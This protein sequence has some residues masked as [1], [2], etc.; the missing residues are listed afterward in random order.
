M[1][2]YHNRPDATAEALDRDGWLRTGD[3]GNLD[4]KGFLTI[5]DRKKDLIKTSAGKYVAPR[6]LEGRLALLPTEFSVES[7]ELTP[8]LKPRRRVIEQK[9][10]DV[11][12][13]LYEGTIPEAMNQWAPGREHG[14]MRPS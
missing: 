13:S 8:S 11:L 10:A 7:G 6:A 2:R 9:Y 3:I 14:E 1:R 5:T 4:A 12:A